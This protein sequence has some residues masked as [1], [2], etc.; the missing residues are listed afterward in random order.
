MGFLEREWHGA[1][2]KQQSGPKFDAG[3]DYLHQF[4]DF[5][6]EWGR[7]HSCGGPVGVCDDESD[8]TGV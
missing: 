8:L 3:I 7:C 4:K 2:G 6:I 5:F 1:D